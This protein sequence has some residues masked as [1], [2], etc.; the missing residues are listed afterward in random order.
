M[1]IITQKRINDAK[2]AYPD[3]ASALDHW[4]KTMRAGRYRDFADLRSTFGS[5]DKAG[6]LFVFD[7][8]GNKLRLIAAIHFNSGKVFI[9]YLFTHAE[10]GRDSWKRQ[11]GLQ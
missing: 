6:K 5:V 2:L 8:G 11:E 10:Y 3:T 4:Y 7:I 9:R 1:H